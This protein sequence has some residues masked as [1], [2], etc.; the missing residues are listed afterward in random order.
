MNRIGMWSALSLFIIG[1]VYAITVV[2]GI[3]TTGFTNPIV[4]PILAIMETLTLVSAPL[5]VIIMGAIHSSATSAYK[6]YSLIALAFMIIVAGLTSAV[7]FIGL[8][9]LRQ[10]EMEGIEWPST[11][12][13]VELLAWDLLLG[14]SLLFAAPIFQGCGFK[15]KI[16]INLIITGVLCIT[17]ILGPVTGDMRLQFISVLGYGVLLPFVWLLIAKDFQ[18]NYRGFSANNS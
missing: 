12:Y 17:G 14:L 18:R 1:V 16:R 7:H 9:A 6:I 3:Y 11:L 10:T 4:D 13:A 15:R 2:I 8:T 5:L